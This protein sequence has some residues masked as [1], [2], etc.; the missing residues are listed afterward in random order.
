MVGHQIE[1][2]AGIVDGRLDLGPMTDDSGVGEKTGDF[3]LPET[4]HDPRVEPRE[5]LAKVV[6]LAQ[7]RQPGES[8][9]K[10]LETELF[11]QPMVVGQGPAPL[12]I[13]VGPV[14]LGL[15]SPPATS[16]A[17]GVVNQVLHLGILPERFLPSA[18]PKPACGG[19]QRV[20][21][22]LHPV[23]NRRLALNGAVAVGFAFGVSELLAA[24]LRQPSPI[25]AIGDW[26]IDNVPPPVKDWA[27][28][29]F[30]IYDKLVLVVGIVVV[31]LLLGIAVGLTVRNGRGWAWGAFAG[32]SVLGAVAAGLDPLASTMGTWLVAAV[33]AGSGV[34]VLS[35]LTRPR[36]QG[37]PSR[38]M[39][40][41]RTGSVAVLALAFAGAGRVLASQIRRLAAGR[42][43]VSLPVATETAAAPTAEADL[44]LPD[45]TPIVVPNDDFYRIDTALVVPNVDLATWQ[46]SVTGLVENEYSIDYAE[47]LD[48]PMVER[49]VTLSCVSN[50]VGGDL[51]GNARWLGV[52]LTS[53]LDRAGIRPEAE[54]LVG[55]SVDRF[56]V[57]FPVEAAYDGR[58]ALVAVGMNGEP[59][60]FEHGFPARLVVSGLYGYVSATK[61]L[62]EIH[63]TTWDSFDAYWI[64]RGWAKEAPIK[65]QSRIDTPRPASGIAAGVNP[66][67]GVAWAPHRGILRVE[68]QVD[69]GPWIEAELSSAL[70]KDSWVQWR[71][72]HDFRPGRHSIRVRATDATGEVQDEQRRPPAPDGATGW[73]SVTINTET[74]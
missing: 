61:W 38:R 65:T 37:D 29:T 60:P 13:V 69:D 47:L 50:E 63:L 39:F 44:M 32:F 28:A 21:D 42:D 64:P 3:G 71:I 57:G 36:R 4:G 17:I 73:H 7:D 8:G 23:S 46:L 70:S 30:G 72:D 45:L 2:P 56:T 35:W 33:S 58:Q 48:L 67:A 6:P 62:Q 20:M 12:V 40:L 22:T 66:I 41:L 25:R 52:P 43:E 16:T 68:V 49:Y 26:V 24:L 34:G 9:L 5:G 59:L 19:L 53:I 15:G 27:I 1:G 55:L 10:P 31:G 18:G 11:K 14:Y 54:Q 51:V 74:T